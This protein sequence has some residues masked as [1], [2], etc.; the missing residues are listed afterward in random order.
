MFSEIQYDVWVGGEIS[1]KLFLIQYEYKCSKE[2]MVPYNHQDDVK[3][4][5]SV[6]SKLF[7]K[8]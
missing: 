1:L 5:P 2:L 3:I 6:S 4:I 7:K 8:I